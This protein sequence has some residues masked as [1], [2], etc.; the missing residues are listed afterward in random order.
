MYREDIVHKSPS[1]RFT[2]REAEIGD[3]KTLTQLWYDSYNASSPF[4]RVMT[5]DEPVTRQWWDDVWVM[6]I[7]A[8]PTKIKTFV[9]EDLENDKKLVAF[10]R[11]NVPQADGSVTGYFMPDYPSTW[12]PRLVE[13]FWHGMEKARKEVM[14]QKPHWSGFIG[15]DHTYEN[16]G[17]AYMFMDLICRQSD[18]SGIEI[19]VDSTDLGKR[20]SSRHFDVQ[21][22][23]EIVV[24]Y[25][26][27]E[28]GDSERE[29]KMT[30][31]VRHPR[32]GK[33]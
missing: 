27:E 25:H 3:A 4:W 6:G 10:T 24:K 28:P 18:A 12:D 13:E 7:E 16:N 32:D 5:P 1:S 15:V 21:S 9:V 17:I 30:V 11:I 31:G 29:F 33:S 22:I 19:C 14:G 26:T 8:G 20:I 2:V 23:R